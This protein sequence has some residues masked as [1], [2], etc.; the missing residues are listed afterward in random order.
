MITESNKL[1]LCGVQASIDYK[2][3]LEICEVT[4]ERLYRLEDLGL[5]QR[6]PN[7]NE[8][9]K[10]ILSDYGKEV[11]ADY[12]KLILK[13]RAKKEAEQLKREQE[14]NLTPTQNCKEK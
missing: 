4:A 9:A 12:K 10:Y 14:N 8:W 11:L 7:E 6:N 1:W 3:P 2:A 5:V 13:R